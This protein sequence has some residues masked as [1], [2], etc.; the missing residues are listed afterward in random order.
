MKTQIENNEGD[1]VENYTKELF[2]AGFINFIVKVLM[3][4]VLLIIL[5]SLWLD[6]KY[7]AE[8]LLTPCELCV[9]LNPQFEECF[10]RI[11]KNE[12]IINYSKINFSGFTPSPS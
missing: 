6:Y 11:E 12:Y 5:F 7:K 1:N 9:K 2:Y 4:I 3:I 8:F 10:F